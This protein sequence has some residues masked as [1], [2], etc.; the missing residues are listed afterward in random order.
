MERSNGAN[1]ADLRRSRTAR[2]IALRA[3]AGLVLTCC[4]VAV[5]RDLVFASEASFGGGWPLTF[6]I[7]RPGVSV[8]GRLS[9]IEDAVDPAAFGIDWLF[10]SLLVSLVG[11]TWRRLARRDG[12]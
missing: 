5:H 6:L 10:W 4:S 12:A 9:L 7:D 3:L 1:P 2:Y 8:T 11:T